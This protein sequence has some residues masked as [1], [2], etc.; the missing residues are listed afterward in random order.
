MSEN[1]SHVVIVGG[2]FAGVACAKGLADKKGVRVT[3][4]DKNAYHQ[5][6]PLL[7]QVATA[8]LTP[9]DIEFD[10]EDIFRGHENIE[11]RKA[12]VVSADPEARRRLLH[13]AARALL[14]RGVHAWAGAQMP[15]ESQTPPARMRPANQTK[16]MRITVGQYSSIPVHLEPPDGPQG[17]QSPCSAGKRGPSVKMLTIEP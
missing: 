2:G 4:L 12:E 17:L 11:V 10:L 9:D 7:Y 3:L 6:Q 16:T 14:N 1:G 5:F 15:L 13:G 8:E